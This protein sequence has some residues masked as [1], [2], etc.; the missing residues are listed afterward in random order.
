MFFTILGIISFV[1]FI[2][3]LLDESKATNSS[4]DKSD[5]KVEPKMNAPLRYTLGP[6]TLEE[7]ASFREAALIVLASRLDC[8]IDNVE[9]VVKRDTITDYYKRGTASNSD[10]FESANAYYD[11]LI[12]ELE[13]KMNE[14]AKLTSQS[15]GFLVDPRDTDTGILKSWVSEIILKIRVVPNPFALDHVLGDRRTNSELAI[16]S[17]TR[18]YN[19]DEE[20]VERI[21]CERELL[22]M[23][24]SSPDMQAYIEKLDAMM[25]QLEYDIDLSAA[26]YDVKIEDTIEF[27]VL[28]WVM[29]ERRKVFL[30]ERDRIKFKNQDNTD[31]RRISCS[32][33]LLLTLCL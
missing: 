28:T 17:Y 21:F 15:V 29:E 27:L 22:W 12:G 9:D 25:T 11:N 6:A 4:R 23:R 18:K 2:K 32:L 8:E 14:T 19:C 10:G 1:L 3:F 24:T 5:S 26:I 30:S 16:E 33:L 7:R 13:Q 20:D 31:K